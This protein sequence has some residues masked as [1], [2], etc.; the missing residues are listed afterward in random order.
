V[1]PIVSGNMYPELHKQ[2]LDPTEFNVLIL[3][4]LNADFLMFLS[5]IEVLH[6][7][8]ADK[9][10]DGTHINIHAIKD[11]KKNMFELH[12]AVKVHP[13]D[14]LTPEAA[15]E[16]MNQLDIDVVLDATPRISDKEAA[17]SDDSYKVVRDLEGLIA[18]CETFLVGRNIP[19]AFRDAM[20]NM[21]WFARYYT[22]PGLCQDTFSFMSETKSKHGYNDDQVE[23][24]RYLVNRIG[25]VE[26]CNDVLN[27]FI[28]KKRR[29]HRHKM[30]N[31]DYSFE[32]NYHLSNYYFL[33]SGGLDITARLLN[34]VF[35]LGITNHM[36][37]GLE[38]DDF[39]AKLTGASPSLAKLYNT[40]K[41]KEW[42]SWLKE[43]RNFIAHEA[44]MHHT[45]IVKE[46]KKKMTPAELEQKI[47]E[48][49]DW[50]L[51]KTILTPELYQAQRDMVA[52]I[53]SLD[54]YEQVMGDVMVVKTKGNT[55]LFLPLRAIDHDNQLFH[56]IISK[57]IAILQK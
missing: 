7:Y 31:Q 14:S 52:N 25:Q 21:T 29:A 4:T 16:L 26:Y 43:R 18:E 54:D 51:L 49:T 23:R 20:W 2:L 45:P 39:I 1:S 44:G 34:D 57:T 50:G 12:E 37:L 38:K 56:D 47:D 33:I 48:Q 36:G 32:L 19:W 35:N 41:F 5:Q 27:S 13:L 9:F 24:L 30:K 3:G 6:N 46:K 8:I 15:F 22:Q 28:Q 10:G 11:D 40:K 55:K 42:V 17:K 53:V